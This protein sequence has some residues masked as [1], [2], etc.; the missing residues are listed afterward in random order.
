MTAACYDV[1][2]VH[3]RT[4]PVRYR[5]SFTGR[6]WLVDL[7]DVPALPRGLRGL[8]RFDSADHL[9]GGSLR[10]DLDDWLRRQ[11]RPAPARVLM[12]ANPRVLGYVFNPL[13]L[14]YCLDGA[15]AVSCVVAEVRNTYGGRHCY[16]LQPDATGQARA[17]KVFYV[18]PYYP[19]DGGYRM[20]LPLPG[21]RLLVN[22]QLHRP[23]ERPFTALV[24]G[25][26]R[27]ERARLWT[28]LRTPLATRAVMFGIRRHGIT[29]YAKG[30]RPVPQAGRG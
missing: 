28:A 19:V 2:I 6:L 26:R 4:D 5:F 12:L 9:G 21:D 8:C 11:G 27:S 25:T 13:T 10:V 7:D 1:R 29:L 15:D 14:F 17:E 23:G 3:R 18:S 16:L 24:A 30:L 22:V 20:R